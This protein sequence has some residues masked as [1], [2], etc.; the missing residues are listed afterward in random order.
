MM[1]AARHDGCEIEA[2]ENAAYEAKGVFVVKRSASRNWEDNP[3]FQRILLF[4]IFIYNDIK[5]IVAACD[6]TVF[7][8]IVHLCCVLI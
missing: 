3:N 8:R 2:L 5:R 1:M 4:A 6:T 7:Q